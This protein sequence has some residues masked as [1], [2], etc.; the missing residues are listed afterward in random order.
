M[1]NGADKDQMAFS[2]LDL[3]CL[4]RQG[5]SGF[6]RIRANFEISTGPFDSLSHFQIF[7]LM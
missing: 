2:T 5:I 1:A 4:Q 7:A 6:S 3:H